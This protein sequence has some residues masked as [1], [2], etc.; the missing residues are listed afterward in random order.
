MKP[1]E[2]KGNT[3]VK[4]IVRYRP[5]NEIIGRRELTVVDLE[6]AGIFTQ[7][8]DLAWDAQTG[9]WL[10]ADEAGISKEVLDLLESENFSNDALG[11]FVIEQ[12]QVEDKKA[13]SP[14]SAAKAAK[15]NPQV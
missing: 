8:K 14:P 1:K 11:H 13:P 12:Q 6:R 2:R 15:D 7:E 4:T 9:F 3:V 10:D 5:P